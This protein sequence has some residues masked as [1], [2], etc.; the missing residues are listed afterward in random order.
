MKKSILFVL[1]ALAAPAALADIP[2]PPTPVKPGVQEMVISGRDA[3]DLIKDLRG[4]YVRGDQLRAYVSSYN[5]FRSSTG[6]T[7]IVC[8][9]ESWSAPTSGKRTTCTISKST[10][11]EKLPKFN[12]PIRMG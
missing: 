5:V 8:K 3:V 4:E 12:P 10:N 6:F 9:E 11:G 1:L 7:Q 2:A